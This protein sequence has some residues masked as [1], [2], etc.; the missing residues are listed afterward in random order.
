VEKANQN[1]KSE[2]NKNM[3]VANR[4]IKHRK[5]TAY[6]EEVHE[7]EGPWIV[8]YA[9]M[10]TLLFCF[11]AILT[12]FANFDAVTVAK[13]SGE[14]SESL[15]DG[16]QA[17]R[18]Q[19]RRLGLEIGGHP[20][21]QGVAKTSLKDGTLEVVFSSSLMFP[22]GDVSISASFINNIDIMVG[23]IKNK[24]PDYRIIVEGHT[25]S[26]K[27][28]NTAKY[29]SNWELSSARSA[30]VVERFLYYDFKPNQLVS[31]GFGNSRPVAPEV[32]KFGEIIPEN[33]ALNRRVVIKVLQPLKSSKMRNVGIE[34]YFEDSEINEADTPVLEDAVQE[35]KTE[36]KTELKLEA[37]KEIKKD[38]N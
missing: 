13:K 4:H 29:R 30:S 9:D 19:S 38:A 12:S 32:D 25:D 27:L 16:P 15:S 35:T 14:L 11:F 6:H 2:N 24:N 34:T 33:Q 18:E 3:S 23:L 37:T 22:P 5:T 1:K 21:L 8:S 7:G 36:V 20:N 26:S 31:V 17:E 10:M 28:S